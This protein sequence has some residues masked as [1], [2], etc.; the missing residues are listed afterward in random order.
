MLLY[1]TSESNNIKPYPL[2][3]ITYS[4]QR[5]L[6]TLTASDTMIH[7]TDNVGILSLACLSAYT[8]SIA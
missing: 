8:L 7:V 4:I 6:L 3:A 2:T 1:V 5:I